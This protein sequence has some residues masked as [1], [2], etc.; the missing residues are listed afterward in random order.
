MKKPKSKC[1][2]Y[3]FHSHLIQVDEGN[4]KDG[5]AG[6]MHKSACLRFHGGQRRTLC[7][8]PPCLLCS[9]RPCLPWPSTAVTTPFVRPKEDASRGWLLFASIFKPL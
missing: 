1:K 9:Q 4:G 3:L 2:I 8:V 7:L 6:C 5:Y